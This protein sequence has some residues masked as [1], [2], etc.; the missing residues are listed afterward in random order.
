MIPRVAWCCQKSVAWLQ[1]RAPGSVVR[2]P[3]SVVGVPGSV[4]DNSVTSSM[5]SVTSS[6]NSVTRSMNSVGS[7]NRC[8]RHAENRVMMV[9][10]MAVEMTRLMVAAKR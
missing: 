3:G 6:M 2:V 8:R 10:A 9:A 5:N 1:N 4:V 7:T